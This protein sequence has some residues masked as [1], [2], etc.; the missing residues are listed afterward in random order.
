MNLRPNKYVN[1]KQLHN[2]QLAKQTKRK[3]KQPKETRQT[4]TINKELKCLNYLI[5]KGLRC[6]LSKAPFVTGKM[7]ITARLRTY[8]ENKYDIA[9]RHRNATQLLLDH[10][11]HTERFFNSTDFCSI[12]N[13]SFSLRIEKPKLLTFFR[14]QQ[15]EKETFEYKNVL[16]YSF[17]VSDNK[18]TV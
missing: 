7:E 16:H 11:F 1:Y 6:S 12:H 18:W 5:C 2:G 9:H 8:L 3:T 10:Q 14:N 17:T 13:N 15:L 4:T